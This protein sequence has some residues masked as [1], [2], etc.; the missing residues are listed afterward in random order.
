MYTVQK[1]NRIVKVSTKK[2][3]KLYLKQC[4]VFPFLCV[5][6]LTTLLILD[7]S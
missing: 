5:S 6:F 1:K 2:L 7:C 3:F 4:V